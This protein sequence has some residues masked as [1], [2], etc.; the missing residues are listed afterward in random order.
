MKFSTTMQLDALL[1]AI[2]HAPMAAKGMRSAEMELH[3]QIL[4]D[5]AD[6]LREALAREQAKERGQ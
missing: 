4:H 6:R 5:L 3:E 2:R 1:L